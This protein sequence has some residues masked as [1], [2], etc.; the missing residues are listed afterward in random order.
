[1]SQSELSGLQIVAIGLV[2]EKKGR[3][4]E[5]LSLHPPDHQETV[6]ITYCI[7]LGTALENLF[8]KFTP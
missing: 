8:S 6:L 7:K 3:T 5:S 1:M 4:K 2:S